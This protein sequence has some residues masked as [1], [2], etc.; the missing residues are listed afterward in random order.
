MAFSVSFYIDFSISPNALIQEQQDG[1]AIVQTA[2]THQE[3]SRAILFLNN[4]GQWIE[5]DLNA[6]QGHSAVADYVS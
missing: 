4:S 2:L 1:L 3:K 5:T 6:S